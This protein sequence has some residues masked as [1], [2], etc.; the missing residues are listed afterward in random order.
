MRHAFAKLGIKDKFIL[1]HVKTPLRFG[2]KICDKKKNGKPTTW[3]I[4]LPHEFFAR[5]LERPDIFAKVFG[6]RERHADSWTMVEARGERWWRDHPCRKKILSEG[7]SYREVANFLS[8]GA[9]ASIAHN[10]P[11]MQERGSQSAK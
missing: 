3:P 6:T 2:N 9:H 11:H 4:L 8:T 7:L 5:M 1:Y 10:T